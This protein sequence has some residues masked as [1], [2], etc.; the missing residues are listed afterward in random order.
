MSIKTDRTGT[1]KKLKKP[2]TFN[3]KVHKSLQQ[4][5]SKDNLSSRREKLSEDRKEEIGASQ[6]RE[7]GKIWI[8]R[9]HEEDNLAARKRGRYDIQEIEVQPHPKIN[10]SRRADEEARR[11]QQAKEWKRR[12]EEEEKREK[13]RQ[14][15][16][17]KK[18]REVMKEKYRRYEKIFK[19]IQKISKF[20]HKQPVPD[21]EAKKHQQIIDHVQTVMTTFLPPPP[22]SE[23]NRID[24]ASERNTYHLINRFSVRKGKVNIDTNYSKNNKSGDTNVQSFSGLFRSELKSQTNENIQDKKDAPKSKSF[25]KSNHKSEY[26]IP[27]RHFQLSVPYE[28]QQQAYLPQSSSGTSIL[29]RFA[30]RHT[31]QNPYGLFLK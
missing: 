15:V 27:I 12:L 26:K 5:E 19:H 24:K 8:A 2:V 21:E 29:S 3:I 31:E 16:E 22:V 1:G 18:Q 7:K 17:E 25:L 13:R 14:E 6:I 28:N 4:S 23:D 20:M 9:R 11:E 30:K 10:S